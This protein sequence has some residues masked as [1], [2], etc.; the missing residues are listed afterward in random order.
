MKVVL[1]RLSYIP[2]LAF[3]CLNLFAFIMSEK[4]IFL[5]PAPSYPDNAEGF[6]EIV[7]G[8]DTRIVGFYH[9][10]AEPGGPVLLWS[11]GNSED[12]GSIRSLLSR[13]AQRGLGYLAYDYPGYGLSGGEPSEK[14]TYRAADEAYRYLTEQ[15]NHR[16]EDIFLVGQSVGSGPSSYLAEKGA[17]AALILISPFKSTFRVLTQVKILPWDRFDNWKRMKNIRIP[18]L[19]THGDAEEVVPYS[20]GKEL[21]ARHSGDS[22][23]FMSLPGVGHNDLWPLADDEVGDTIIRFITREW[24]GEALE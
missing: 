20:H 18:L 8:E 6:V 4:L 2:L 9:P 19:R 24:S 21:F 16:E 14:G 23:E 3:L 22:K 1:L 12:A 17:G 15:R 13:F 7:E 11:H 10:P 5:P